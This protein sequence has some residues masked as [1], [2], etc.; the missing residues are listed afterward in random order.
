MVNPS[1]YV[2]NRERFA[3]A[4]PDR[5]AALLF[6]GEE[7]HMS[8]DSDYRFFPDRN[9][10][11]LTGLERPGFVLVI[12]KH[13][14]RISS[15]V[16]APA[17][18]SMKERWHGKRMDFADIAAIAGLSQ[19]D[20]LDLE[21]YEE[22]EYELIRNTDINIFLDSTSVMNKPKDLKKLIEKDGRK[23]SDLSE[24]TTP[25]RMVKSQHEIDSIRQAAKITEEA[26]D[27][28]KKLIKPG[29]SEYELYLK[30]EYEMAKRSSMSFA[31]ETIVSCGKNA[32]YLHHSDPERDG[33]GIAKDGSIVQIDCGARMNGCCADISRVFFVGKPEG[34]NDKR[35]LLLGL[36]QELRKAAFGYI[37]P[38]K[39]FAGLNSQMYDITGKWLAGQGLIPDNFTNEDVKCYYWHNTSHYLGMDVHDVGPRDKEFEA[40]NCLAVEPGVYIPEWDIGFRIEDDCLVTENGCQLL[41]SGCDSPEGIIVG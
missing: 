31:F 3:A 5:T 39:T 21:K 17:H 19:E 1:F 18:D 41:S 10:Y 27:E 36:I 25:L 38:G 15:K 13:D 33:D 12:E 24:I 23:T 20:V 6:S 22:K 2:N 11:Y 37:A 7:K 32:F 16:Y 26:I 30:L 40:G 14:G 9:F 34:E 4:L 28:M 29:V 35:I 8:L